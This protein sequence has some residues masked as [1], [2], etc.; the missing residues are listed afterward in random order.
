M[1]K[2][3]WEGE[4]NLVADNKLIITPDIPYYIRVKGDDVNNKLP[5]KI[6]YLK[7]PKKLPF[8]EELKE[9]LAVD[10]DTEKTVGKIPDSVLYRKVGSET[11]WQVGK[12]T[13]IDIEAGATYDFKLIYKDNSYPENERRYSSNIYRVNGPP[14]APEFQITANDIDYQTE[15]F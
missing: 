9:N 5:S 4:P 7:V 11:E 1:V 14:R 12:N 10:F 6:K 8:P 2:L 15:K 3:N 13:E